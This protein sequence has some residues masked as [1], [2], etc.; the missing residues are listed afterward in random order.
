MRSGIR[1]GRR[2]FRGTR[3]QKPKREIERKVVLEFSD[4]STS[5]DIVMLGNKKSPKRSKAVMI[6]DSESE[7]EPAQDPFVMSRSSGESSPQRPRE[8]PKSPESE[9]LPEK[10]APIES[11]K[12]S[13]VRPAQTSSLRLLDRY[14]INR[15][16]SVSLS[17]LNK[18]QNHYTCA[19]KGGFGRK[20]F[21]LTDNGNNTVVAGAEFTG[22]F[23]SVMQMANDKGQISEIHVSGKVFEVKHGIDTCLTIARENGNVVVRAFE[24]DGMKPP[25]DVLVGTNL[26]DLE[27]AFG[28]RKVMPSVKNCK[29][30]D[31]SGQEVISVRKISNMSLA[32]DTR[33]NV[34][35]ITGFAVAIYM[36]LVK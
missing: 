5:D 6:T 33:F 1:G 31:P 25:F 34:S 19:K 28:D 23:S 10:P 13:T 18:E 21:Q 4:S 8:P 26:T 11:P 17:H 2:P 20:I 9:E 35:F 22:A 24:L 27:A 16:S 12:P 7:S 30:C 3:T 14:R 32:V 15:T 29:L 36:F